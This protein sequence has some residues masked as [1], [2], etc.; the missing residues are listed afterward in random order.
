MLLPSKSQLLAMGDGFSQ[1]GS[2]LGGAEQ[3]SGR[4]S[5]I[6]LIPVPKPPS[7]FCSPVLRRTEAEMKDKVSPLRGGCSSQFPGDGVEGGRAP[8]VSCKEKAGFLTSPAFPKER[9]PVPACF[10]KTHRALI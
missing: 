5:E 2:G 4:E 1:L 9:P 10:H 3:E 8:S 6:A 7:P